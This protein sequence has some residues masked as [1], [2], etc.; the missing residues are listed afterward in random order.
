MYPHES[1][2]MLCTLFGKTRQGW[3]DHFQRKKELQLQETFILKL[4]KEI[5]KE[6]KRMGADKIYHLIKPQLKEHEIKYGR[7]KLY[8]LMHRH[9]LLTRQ[10]KRK[11][12]TTDSNHPFKWFPNLI[13]DIVLTRANQ[14]W[15][16]DITYIRLL[17][18]FAYLSLITDAYSHKIVG[19]C[20]YPTLESQG[21]IEALK[22]AIEGNKPVY[23][24][25][26]HSDRGIQYCCVDYVNHLEFYHISLSMSAKGDP[27]E[28]AIAERVNGILKDEYELS[29]TY[30]NF[31]KALEAVREAVFKYNQKR[32]HSSCD[33][34][35][36]VQAHEMKG[37][38]KKR[39]KSLTKTNKNSAPNPT[40]EIGF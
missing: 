37:T 34:L 13:K 32:P 28:N 36:P 24:L 3:Y 26:H 2:E 23:G 19:W 22:M 40:G 15:V 9:G 11:P 1:M 8:N 5:K 27:Y 30:G 17:G 7:D 35:T 21:A 25:I 33:Y 31:D 10:R 29:L 18:S 14:L 39:W 12:R 38:L 4:V 6:H 16:S 20:L